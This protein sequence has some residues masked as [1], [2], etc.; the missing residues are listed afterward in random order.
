MRNI[1]RLVNAVFVNLQ[2]FVPTRSDRAYISRQ[3]K[4]WITTPSNFEVGQTKVEAQQTNDP[5]LLLVD[6]GLLHLQIVIIA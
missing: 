5:T 3:L 4:I 1:F 6:R 2:H